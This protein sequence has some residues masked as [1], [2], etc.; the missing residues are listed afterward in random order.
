MTVFDVRKR[1]GGKLIPIPPVEW[2]D[3]IK[4]LVKTMRKEKVDWYHSKRRNQ[5]TVQIVKLTV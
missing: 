1:E 5:P 2:D 4:S 3:H